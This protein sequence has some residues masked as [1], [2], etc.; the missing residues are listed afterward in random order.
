ML[1]CKFLSIALKLTL[2]ALSLPLF[3][4]V[5][6]HAQGSGDLPFRRAKH[7]QHGVN[8]SNWF[9][10][11][12]NYSPQRLASYTTA[13]DIHLMRRLGFDHVR[14]GIDADALVRDG[15][16]DGLN[17]PFAAQLDASVKTM[18]DDG[19]AVIIDVHPSDSYKQQLA[20][21]P[22]AVT[23]FV[24]LWRALA[25]H[26]APLDPERV[27]FE[28]L[29]EP[30]FEDGAQW[31]HVESAAAA[32]IRQA[33]PRHTIIAA[34]FHYS[35]LQDLLTLDPIQ[36]ANQDANV[37]YTFHDYEPFPFTHQGATWAGPRMIPLRRIPY[38]S[39]PEL[40]TPLL[41]EESSLYDQ[42]WLNSYGLNRWDAH[43]IASEVAFATRWARLHHVPVY[44]GEF[45]VL[46]KNA[47]PAMR[48]AW[49]HDMRAALEANG[50]GWAMWDYSGG[51][52]VVEKTDGGAATPDPLIVRAL[53]LHPQ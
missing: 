6:A 24:A 2:L 18:L 16:A 49:I 10:Q 31:W 42:F 1:S 37:I 52:G 30:E 11:A 36:I 27:F 51:F 4:G 28:V 20:K 40:L 5:F 17:A 46:R 43:R 50:I 35:G 14:L 33:A 29:N 12:E 44:C 22:A 25:A 34:P 9:S 21:D 19:L 32:A 23:Q 26:F 7:L 3:T 45:G 38:P 48:A 53:G 47:D 15:G 41:D 13:A 8:A 39:T